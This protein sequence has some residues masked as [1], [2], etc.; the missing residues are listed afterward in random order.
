MATRSVP[1]ELA[2]AA[3]MKPGGT[4]ARCADCGQ[5]NRDSRRC[6]WGAL[7]GTAC[8]NRGTRVLSVNQLWQSWIQ[9]PPPH[10]PP[11][12]GL[13]L[14]PAQTAP[15]QAQSNPGTAPSGAAHD[16]CNCRRAGC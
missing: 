11:A 4:A 7:F 14:L 12:P 13:A 16:A 9:T 5:Q 3:A 15:G 1:W 10:H 2:L 8:R 6:Q